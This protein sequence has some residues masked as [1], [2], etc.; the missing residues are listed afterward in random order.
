MTYHFLASSNWQRI[1]LRPMYNQS[2][3]RNEDHILFHLEQ[4]TTGLVSDH[5]AFWFCSRVSPPIFLIQP[6]ENSF[7]YILNFD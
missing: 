2:F 1:A 5:N 7:P 6:P 3:P 4:R